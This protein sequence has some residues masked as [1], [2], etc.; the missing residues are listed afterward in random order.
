MRFNNHS[1]TNRSIPAP[2]DTHRRPQTNP[3]VTLLPFGASSSAWGRPPN[4]GVTMLPPILYRVEVT[5]MITLAQ[6]AWSWGWLY[7]ITWKTILLVR[8][9]KF[10]IYCPLHMFA[11]IARTEVFL[12][13]LKYCWYTD[14]DF[15]DGQF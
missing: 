14:I 10:P 12:L 1:Q 15:T 2:D 4:L 11:F 3:S 9:D 7:P 6:L 13:I 5:H 8:Q